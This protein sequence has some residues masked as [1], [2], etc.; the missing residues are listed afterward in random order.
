MIKNNK[1]YCDYCKIEINR[2]I[3][4]RD[5]EYKHHFCC[6]NCESLFK[7]NQNTSPKKQNEIIIKEN[8]AIIK[9]NSKNF[10]IL[11]CLI[12][13]EDI[14]KINHL[15]WRVRYDKRHPNC[16]LYVEA[17]Y[18]N[19]RV[20]LH[21]LLTDCPKNMIV[22]HI[23][24]NGL[25]NKK[26]N[27]RICTQKENSIN[28]H[29]SKTVGVRYVKRNDFWIACIKFKRKLKYLGYYRTQ[30]E[31]IKRREYVNNLIKENKFDII[32]NL[33]CESIGAYRNNKLGIKGICKLKNNYYQVHHKGKYIGTTKTLEEA[34]KI[35]EDYIANATIHQE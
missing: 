27:L 1:L 6:K 2:N 14:E 13:I 28:R 31:A 35:K 17:T 32:E 25:N 23:D 10:G 5:K 34:I 30:E 33:E 12:D 8:Y 20:H 11:D 9:L 15:Y 3:R 22:D 26:Q 21:R 4:Q 7:K 24:G 16:T 29:N 18:K 19:K